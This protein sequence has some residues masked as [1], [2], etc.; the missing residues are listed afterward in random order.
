MLLGQAAA[1]WGRGGLARAVAL[2][3]LPGRRPAEVRVNESLAGQSDHAGEPVG[4]LTR[5]NLGGRVGTGARQGDNTLVV[6]YEAF[7]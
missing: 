6:C 2:R 5:R 7:P 4:E 1:E 3:P